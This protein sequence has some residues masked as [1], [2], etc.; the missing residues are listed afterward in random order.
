MRPEVLLLDEPTAGLDEEALDHVTT[1]LTGLPQAMLVIS[2][3]RE[4]LSRVVE[5]IYRLEGGRLA[6]LAEGVR[7]LH[8]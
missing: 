6:P 8:N 3:D 7:R 4:F 5:R 2:H 1:I